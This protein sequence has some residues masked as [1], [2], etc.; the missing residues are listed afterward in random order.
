MYSMS[1]F[2]QLSKSRRSRPAR[3]QRQVSP[4]RIRRRPALPGL[5]LRHFV[6]NGRARANQRHVAFQNVPQLRPFIN[7][8]F[9]KEVAHS[10]SRGVIGDFEGG[11]FTVQM[12]EGGLQ[13]FRVVAHGSEFIESESAPVQSRSVPAGRSQVRW[14][15]AG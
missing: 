14:R 10:V 8:E 9:A 11:R 3:V 4:G 1:S 5:V 12:A 15:S 7:G 2:I 6:G 13:F